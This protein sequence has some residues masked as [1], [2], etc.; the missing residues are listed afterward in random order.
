ML[1]DIAKMLSHMAPYFDMPSMDNI[2][3]FYG[4]YFAIHIDPGS[5]AK[6]VDMTWFGEVTNLIKLVYK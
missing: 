2:L 4:Q 1:N 6:L 5:N 3:P